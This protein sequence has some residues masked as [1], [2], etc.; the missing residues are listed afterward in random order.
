MAGRGYREARNIFSSRLVAAPPVDLPEAHVLARRPL[1]RLLLA[2]ALGLVTAVVVHGRV[3]EADRWGATRRVP[4]VARA[5]PAGRVLGTDDVRTA[6][7]PVAALPEADVAAAPVGR[8]TLVALAAGEVVLASRVAPGTGLAGLV[9]PGR[10]AVAVPRSPATPAVSVG[11]R[12][13]VV[14]GDGAGVV[15]PEA[16]VV[17]VDDRSVTVAVP[18][19]TA[20]RLAGAVL[21]GQVSL[22]LVGPTS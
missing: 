18:A 13:D 21:G 16:S 11:D 1:P 22:A 17:A 15:A 2:A 5:V 8:V 4:V 6:V 3:A 20:P 10:R 9:P 12:V 19:A 14:G 7:I